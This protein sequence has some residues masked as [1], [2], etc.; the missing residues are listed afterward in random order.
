MLARHNDWLQRVLAE[1]NPH[2]SA[3]AGT[4]EREAEAVAEVA[5]L[6]TERERLAGEIAVMEYWRDGF[7]KQGLQ[8]LLVDEIATQFNAARGAIFPTLTQGVYDVQFSTVS[9]TKGGEARERTEFHVYEHGQLVPYAA[10]SGG[11]RRRVD[12]GVMLTLI[13]AVSRWLQVPGMLGML[14]LDEVLGFLDASGA[15][16]LLEV[17]REVQ[18]QIPAIFVVSH[19]AHVQ[20]LFPAVI[21][22]EQDA[23]GVSRLVTGSTVE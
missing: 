19:E 20:G 14:V 22:V 2:A 12:V 16:G 17:L 10:L 4:G 21:S 1:Q 18:E 3:L 11:Q 6:T 5:R 9:Q 7:S 23:A 15:E 8:S 13:M